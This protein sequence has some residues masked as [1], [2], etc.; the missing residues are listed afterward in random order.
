[1]KWISNTEKLFL[2][3]K[4]LLDFDLHHGN[5]N[6]RLI[7]NLIQLPRNLARNNHKLLKIKVLNAWPPEKRRFNRIKQVQNKVRWQSMSQFVIYLSS[8]NHVIYITWGCDLCNYAFI[9]DDLRWICIKFNQIYG[10]GEIDHSRF[11]S[12]YL[13]K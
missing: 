3:F 7:R 11:C 6:N 2:H 4:K 12:I 9:N 8:S 13:L 10:E 5:P 1:M